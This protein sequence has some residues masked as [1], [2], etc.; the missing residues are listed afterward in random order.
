MY[1][2]REF[3]KTMLAGLP[4][5]MA[6]TQINSQ[7]NSQLSSQLSS[8]FRGVQIGAITYSFR[9]LP[10][11]E[12]IAAMVKVGLSEA[13]LMSNHCEALAGAPQTSGL[14]GPGRG[15]QVW[16]RPT[17]MPAVRRPAP[18]SGSTSAPLR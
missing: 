18:H 12:I 13:E 1:S 8:K 14:G 4:V 2:R 15:L 17:P 9:S 7:L 5:S 6:L 10:A 3:A 11:N 16:G